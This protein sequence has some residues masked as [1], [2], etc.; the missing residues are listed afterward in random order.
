MQNPFVYW[1]KIAARRLA[2]LDY[3]QGQRNLADYLKWYPEESREFTRAYEEVYT[4]LL[5]E[6]RKSKAR[7]SE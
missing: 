5:W 7:V 4:S 6:D 2:V 1:S 3:L